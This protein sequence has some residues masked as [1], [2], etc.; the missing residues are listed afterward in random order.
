[1][2][3]LKL[4]AWTAGGVVALVALL[5]AAVLL[6]VNPNDYK[7]RI[8]AGV[9]AATGRSLRLPGELKLS[10]FPWLALQVGEAQLGNPPGFGD[11][12]FLKL[13]SAKLRVKLLPL[14]LQRKLEVDRVEIDVL[15]TAGVIQRSAFSLYE[16][17]FKTAVIINNFLFHNRSLSCSIFPQHSKFP[18]I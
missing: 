7:D 18:C 10:V 12:P 4:L 6:F 5:L 11:E 17:S 15:S 1:M 2:R 13:A 9:Q 3:A 16:H 14:L 8:E